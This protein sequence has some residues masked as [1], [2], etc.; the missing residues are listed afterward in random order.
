LVASITLIR[1]GL[2]PSCRVP[3]VDVQALDLFDQHEDR[4]PGCTEIFAAS[5]SKTR[6]PS[7]GLFNLALVQT[8]AQKSSDG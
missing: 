2:L 6:A 4:S 1:L 5:G 3:Q 8:I 7:A